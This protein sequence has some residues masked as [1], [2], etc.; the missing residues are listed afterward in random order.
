VIEQEPCCFVHRELLDNRV[1]QLVSYPDQLVTGEVPPGRDYR[2][3]LRELDIIDGKAERAYPVPT[4][5]QPGVLGVVNFYTV[6]ERSHEY[7]FAGMEKI[8]SNRCPG[9]KVSR[10]G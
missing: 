9:G 6:N 1:D 7:W 5:L 10:S 2:I 4:G 8:I 3:Q